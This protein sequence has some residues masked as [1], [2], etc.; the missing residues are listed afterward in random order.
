[1]VYDGLV[2]IGVGEDP[3]HGEGVGHLWCIDPNKHGDVSPELVF[4]S[5]SP[6]EPIPHKR[7][8]AC[9]EAEGDFT[10]ANPNSAAIWHY[11]GEDTNGNKKLEF[12]ET[13][14]RTCGTVAI[15]DGLLFIA[16]F[17]G[18]FHCLD[19]KTGK[20]HWTYDMLAA[21][22]A[23][24]MIADGKVYIGDEDGDITVF[25]CSAEQEVLGENNMGSSVYSTP[26]VANGVLFIANKDKLFAIESQKK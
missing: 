7:N 1:V 2:Y 18:L 20:P 26:I 3:E 6:E 16:D 4:N 14:H 23:S 15:Q 13:M 11:T 5:Q 21:S 17:S 25:A 8:Q 22:W 12:E 10:R 19:V 9:V 24:P